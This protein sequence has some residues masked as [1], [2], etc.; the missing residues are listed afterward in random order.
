MKSEAE[1]TLE[2]LIREEWDFRMR[3]DPIFA[4][5][6]GD[7]R[8]NDCLPGMTQEDFERQEEALRG[9]LGRLEGIDRDGLPA[10]ARLNRDFIERELR[11]QLGEIEF[12]IQYIP[13]TKSAGLPVSFP[14]VLNVTPFRTV[15]DYENYIQRLASFRRLAE[16]TIDLMQAG[17]RAGFLPPRPAMAGVLDGF[18]QHGG[19]ALEASVFFAPFQNMPAEFDVAVRARLRTEGTEA[20]QRFV[21]PGFQLLAD[22]LEQ[23]YLPQTSAE[24]AALTMPRAKEYYAFCVRRYTSLDLTPEE[25]HATGLS[26]VARIRAEMEE[27]IRQVGFKGS[28]RAFADELRRDER[29]FVDSPERL[30]KEVAFIL[31]KIE[32]QLPSLFKTLPRTP[33]GLRETP[34]FQ[35]PTSTSAYYFPPAGDGS[36]AGFYYVNTYDLPSRPFY[37]YEALSMH[38]AVPGHHLQLALQMEMGQVP[39][40]RKFSEVTAFVEGWALYAERLGLEMGFYADPYTNFGRLIYEMWRAA[41]LVVDTGLHYYG[42]SRQRAI[43]YL[44]ENTALSLLNIANEVDRYISW[45]GQALAYKIGELKIRELRRRAKQALGSHFDL[46]AFHEV[47]LREGGI[48]LSVLVGNVNAWL[49]KAG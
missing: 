10:E 12:G 2:Q 9:F 47:I 41:R 1:Q 40:F 5:Y 35:A 25:V 28:L 24:G 11:I 32:G 48:P 8:Y 21:Q 26:E 16:Q 39:D 38:E 30:M 20:I 4:T 34:A 44:A 23:E 7:H 45:P 33:L 46:R 13:L 19:C 49:E 36:T 15:G 43:D 27:V 17:M 31:K 18:R 29:F 42:W 14:D 6:C 3:E 37:E 22:F